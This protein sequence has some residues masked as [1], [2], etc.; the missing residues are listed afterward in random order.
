MELIKRFFPKFTSEQLLAFEKLMPLYTEWNSK[1]NVISRKDMENLYERH[2]LHS[3]AIAR[4]MKFQNSSQILD[5]GTGGGFPGIP[6]AIAFPESKFTLLDAIG[7]KITVVKAV[8]EALNLNN[9]TAIHGNVIELKPK[10]NFI[11]SRG[12]CAFPEFVAL[13]RKNIS[14][15]SG[16]QKNG[17]IYLKG[18]D[19]KEELADFK[20]KVK[21]EDISKW[22]PLEFFDTKKIVY[23]PV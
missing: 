13:T 5:V 2:V 20:N 3:L 7:K 16:I 9:V 17:I 8:A 14:H 22:F 12:V 18:G 23:F 15:T 19:L 21:V 4:F 1:I 11:I 6:L 10:F